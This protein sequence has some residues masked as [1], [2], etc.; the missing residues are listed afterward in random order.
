VV[1]YAPQRELLS[2]A[3]L[4]VSH[5]GLNTVLDSL[6]YGVPVVAVPITYEQ[7]AI[8]GRLRYTGAGESIALRALNSRRLR[9]IICKVMAT[10]S[11]AQGAATIADA[12]RMAGGVLTAADIILTIK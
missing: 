1:G 8:A 12:I 10:D 11:Y 3:R 9:N 4:T 7:P 6:T 5:A 2:R